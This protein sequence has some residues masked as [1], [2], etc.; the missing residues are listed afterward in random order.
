MPSKRKQI[1]VRADAETEA[2]IKRLLPRVR[3]A[4]GLEVTVSDLFRMGMM[5]LERRYGG[6]TGEG[7]A[8]EP[9]KSAPRKKGG[10]K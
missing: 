3:E 1:N 10:R 6:K 7:V 5:E 4:L 9:K 2:R 8:P